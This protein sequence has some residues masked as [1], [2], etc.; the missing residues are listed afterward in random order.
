MRHF[1][2]FRFVLIFLGVCLGFSAL[3][4]Q[5]KRVLHQTFDVTGIEEIRLDIYGEVELVPWSGSKIM[6]ETTVELAGAPKH[7]L[8][9][10]IEEKKRYDIEEIPG[11]D[12]YVLQSVEKEHREIS[13]KGVV[14][15]EK[16]RV[17][18]FIPEDFEILEGGTVLRRK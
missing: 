2:F 1:A 18:L 6:S 3:Q 15:E 13:Y 14:C 4:A 7:V 5:Q 9:F 12:F 10:F 8:E 17:R 16:V 11:A